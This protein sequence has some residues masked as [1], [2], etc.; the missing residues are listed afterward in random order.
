MG[1]KDPADRRAYQNATRDLLRSLGLCTECKAKDSRTKSGKRLCARCA[2]KKAV[3]QRTY[4][5]KR[6]AESKSLKQKSVAGR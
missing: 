6:K 4:K 2:A 1:W 3:Y 5:K